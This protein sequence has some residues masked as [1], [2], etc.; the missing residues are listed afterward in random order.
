MTPPHYLLVRARRKS[1]YLDEV[2][3]EGGREHVV[4]PVVLVAEYVA[5]VA[6]A[7]VGSQDEHAACVD[8]RAEEGDQVL[9]PN[10]AHLMKLC[11][12]GQVFINQ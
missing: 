2:C 1:S 6:P 10:L 9:V 4:D 11:K 8:A 12:L 5:E 3:D 7:E